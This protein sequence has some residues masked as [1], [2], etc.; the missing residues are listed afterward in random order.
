[1]IFID[2]T[3]AFD[4]ILIKRNMQYR[5]ASLQLTYIFGVILGESE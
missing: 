5:E 2:L 1:M 3:K 4:T